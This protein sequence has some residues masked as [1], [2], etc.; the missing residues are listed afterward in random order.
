MKD[1]NKGYR[2][3]GILVILFYIFNITA[4]MLT[5]YLYR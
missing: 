1:K 4:F 5:T 2:I 3:T